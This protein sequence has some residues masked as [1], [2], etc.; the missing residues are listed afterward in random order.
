MLRHPFREDHLLDYLVADALV[1]VW[2]VPSPRRVRELVVDHQLAADKL[3]DSVLV[4]DVAL[5]LVG[6]PKTVATV[7]LLRQVKAIV[8]M[9]D[10]TMKDHLLGL[11]RRAHV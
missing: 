3:L 5:V 10:G 6:G 8:K 1:V 7:K 2:E 11:D 4:G 9:V